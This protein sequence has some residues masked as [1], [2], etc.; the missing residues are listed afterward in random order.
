MNFARKKFALVCFLCNFF[1][2]TDQTTILKKLRE[3][4]SKHGQQIKIARALAVDSSTVM[5]WR[6]GGNIPDP[7]LVLLD[8]YFFGTPIPRMDAPPENEKSVN[9]TYTW[10]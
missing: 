5:R 9:V 6:D 8:W 7:M 2:V 10:T 1:F 4:C 3:V